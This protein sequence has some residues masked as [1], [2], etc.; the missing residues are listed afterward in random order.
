MES[1][2][3]NIKQPEI[4]KQSVTIEDNK[5]N[6][7]PLTKNTLSKKESDDQEPE[8]QDNDGQDNDDQDNDGQDNDDQDN[9]GQDNDGQDNDDQDNDGQDNDDQD[10]DDQDND[11]QDND[12]QDNDDQ[13]NDDQDNDEDLNLQLG[14]VIEIKATDDPNLNNKRFYIKYIDDKRIHLVNKEEEHELFFKEDGT[15]RNEAIEGVQLL[16]REEFP[17]F[18]K[19]NNLLPLTWIDIHFGG[20]FPKIYTGKITNLEEDQIEIH[21]IELNKKIYLDFEYKGLNPDFEI[22]EII[23]RAP[24]KSEQDEVTT[25]KI[26]K[27]IDNEIKK[28][29]IEEEEDDLDSDE[30]NLPNKDDIQDI[31]D[32]AAINSGEFIIEED[33]GEITIMVDIPESERRYGIDKQANDLL[34]ELLSTIPT[35]KRTPK[36]LNKIHLEIE[37][38]KE[39]RQEFSEFDSYGAIIGFKK[40]GSEHKPL[41]ETLE[42]LNKKLYWMLPVAKSKKKL[43]LD[44]NVITDI[45]DVE[46]IT[47]DYEELSNIYETFINNKLPDEMNRYDDYIKALKRYFSHKELS[48]QIGILNVS[49]VE[50]NIMAILNNGGEYISSSIGVSKTNDMGLRGNKFYLQNYNVGDNMIQNTKLYT[51]EL[52]LT[53]RKVTNA[54]TIAVSSFFSL[55]ESAVHFSRVNLPSTNILLK[56]NL[57]HRFIQYWQLL[58]KKTDYKTIEVTNLD[59]SVNYENKQYLD[60]PT[61]YVLSESIIDTE[62]QNNNQY[63]KYL[64]AII[65]KT[66]TLFQLMKRH[67]NGKLS[68]KEVISYLEPFMIYQKDLSYKQYEE[69]TEFIGEKIRDFKKSY[70]KKSAS[71]ISAIKK[72]NSTTQSNILNLLRSKP[73]IYQKIVDAYLLKNNYSDS[74]ILYYIKKIDNGLLFQKLLAEFNFNLYYPDVDAEFEKLNQISNE[75]K[76]SAQENSNADCKKYV[77]AKQYMAL[78]EMEED[79]NVEIFFDKK[80]DNTY[81]DLMKDFDNDIT[82]ELSVIKEGENERL[83]KIKVIKEKLI[84]NFGLNEQDAN[85]DAETM[86]DGKRRVINGDYA[87]LIN[88]DES[89]YY[90]RN[91]NIWTQDD[92][93]GDDVFIKSSKMFCNLN[94]KCQQVKND[95]VNDKMKQDMLTTEQVKIMLNEF[96]STLEK[97]VAK[98]EEKIKNEI[99]KKE[100]L[101]K[102]LKIKTQSEKFKYNEMFL[103][104]L[105]IEDND[106][107]ISPYEEIRDIILGQSDLV[108]RFGDI[109]KFTRMFTRNPIADD[110]ESIYWLYCPVTNKKLLPS[111]LHKLATSYFENNNLTETLDEICRE[112]GTISDDGD[113]WVDKH[114]GYKIKQIKFEE[115]EGFASDGF[116]LITRDILELDLGEQMAEKNNE[117]IN[118]TEKKI[119]NVVRSMARNMNINIEPQIDFIKK[120]VLNLYQTKYLSESKFK[121]FMQ[122]AAASGKSM[123]RFESIEKINDFSLIIITLT[124]IFIAI[125]I[126]IPGIKTKKSYPNCKRGSL[127]KN[128]GYPLSKMDDKSGIE[129]IA[130]IAHKM[131]SKSSPWS[132]LEKNKEST[133]AKEMIN[134]IEKNLLKDGLINNLLEQKKSFIESGEDGDDF[135]PTEHSIS[136][137]TTFRPIL[138]KTN[139]GLV[140]NIGEGFMDKLESEIM[141]GS[142][143]QT[144]RINILKSKLYQYAISFQEKIQEVISKKTLILTNSLGD[145]FL[146]NACCDEGITHVYDYF[147][148][149]DSNIDIFNKRVDEFKRLIDWLNKRGKAK[150]LFNPNDT[151]L[152]YPELKTSFSEE[153]IYKTFIHYCKLNSTLPISSDLKLICPELLPE[154]SLDDN[155]MDSIDKMKNQGIELN[156]KS[157]EQLLQILS[158]Q[159]AKVNDHQKLVKRKI[160]DF[161]NFIKTEKE[162]DNNIELFKGKEFYAI[163]TNLITFFENNELNED[164]QPMLEFKN[165]LGESIEQMSELIEKIVKKHIKSKVSE[166]IMSTILNLPT[167]KTNGT[168]DVI[169]P[170][171]ETFMKSNDFIIEIINNI[172]VIFPYII[173]NNVYYEDVTPPKHWKLSEKHKMDLKDI[174]QQYYSGLKKHS[175]ISQLKPFIKKTLVWNKKISMLSKLIQYEIPSSG[176]LTTIFDKRLSEQLYIYLYLCSIYNYFKVLD[177]PELYETKNK[178]EFNDA[179]A[180]EEITSNQRNNQENMTNLMTKMLKTYMEILSRDKKVIGF[181]YDEIIERVTKAKEKEKTTIL[182]RIS[183]LSDEE[184]ELDGIFKKHKMGEWDKGLQKG[185]RVYQKETYD[186]EREEME[187]MAKVEAEL[188]KNDMITAMNKDIYQLDVMANQMEEERIEAEEYG[189]DG[190]ADDDD[191]GEL[192]GDEEY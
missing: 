78:D 142:S 187:Q 139:I 1:L 83:I 92:T 69:M 64:Q 50:S 150:I 107:I 20:E 9:D 101:I 109:I 47:S 178:N 15:L 114:S 119:L 36:V 74:E 133:I 154:V 162:E 97:D 158:S 113:Q 182:E 32:E 151:K 76:Q 59:E 89:A 39:L 115:N 72:D 16:A 153:I 35:N 3:E 11:D 75:I 57:N 56:S 10:N 132:A 156:S 17:G 7:K 165:F 99:D 105:Q 65:P 173:I 30:F 135:I 140:Q 123:K 184:K 37:R 51:G 14:D 77:L 52:K 100:K 176:Q 136:T 67:I 172:C 183:A 177:L 189:L 181:T 120:G 175:E 87:V 4:D 45:D 128:K 106:I 40:L 160:L 167:F 25:N 49:Q 73:E 26:E 129:Y 171:I 143:K 104:H 44:N 21:L 186:K 118:E 169:T 68:M 185:L 125:K 71:I 38:Y 88:G 60:I 152:K 84:E 27:E 191:Y 108:K 103:E 2:S 149:Q 18:A 42:K 137:W 131:K 43:Y 179:D 23:I 110:E 62:N 130:C 112:Q 81:Y 70:A 6:E 159:N 63:K 157:L 29:D 145:P 190:L 12:D 98:L 61:E 33:L 122:K 134:H 121:E 166:K 8:G 180:F 141:R 31:V 66:R 28:V 94:E 161:F 124:Y 5:L 58:N 48:E 188:G 126:S 96:D 13:D 95:C 146:E 192:D 46:W 170:E 53:T 138:K 144:K 91:A 174:I 93:V 22:N 168:G 79:N 86:V 164:S 117:E 19:Q 127:F 24:P 82:A 111:F 155:L 55:P 34:D 41:V 85:R 90:V 80:Y 102:M 148:E 116:K 163:I 54:D 147:A